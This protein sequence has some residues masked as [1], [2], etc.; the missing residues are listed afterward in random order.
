MVTGS[1]TRER[2]SGRRVPKR[3]TTHL[4]KLPARRNFSRVRE[5]P[6]ARPNRTIDSNGACAMYLV[7]LK[8]GTEAI[9]SSVA[10]LTEAVRRGEVTPA[11]K[12]FHRARSEWAPITAHPKFR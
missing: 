4:D 11:A 6:A 5:S 8:P 3:K 1:A 7:E 9:Y 2:S 12:V 10:E